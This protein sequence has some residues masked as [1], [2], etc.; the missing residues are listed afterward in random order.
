MDRPTAHEAPAGCGGVACS[1]RDGGGDGEQDGAAGNTRAWHTCF[2][3][4]AHTLHILNSG[5]QDTRERDL[6]TI[7]RHTRQ[8]TEEYSSS[9]GNMKVVFSSKISQS[10]L[11]YSSITSNLLSYT[12]SIKCR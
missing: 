12:W 10:K 9:D 6:E 4:H 11:H 3:I 7:S 5:T 2:V 1:D 8:S